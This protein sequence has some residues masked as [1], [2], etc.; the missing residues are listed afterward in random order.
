MLDDDKRHLVVRDVTNSLSQIKH[1]T[2]ENPG[3]VSIL[4]SLHPHCTVK[5]AVDYVIGL[6]QAPACRGHQRPYVTS[7]KML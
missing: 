3:N 2:Q 7:T 4:H 6:Q 5:G 1:V